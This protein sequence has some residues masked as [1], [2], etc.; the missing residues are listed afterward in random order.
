[1]ILAAATSNGTWANLAG[2]IAVLVALGGIIWRAGQWST[3]FESKLDDHLV[4]DTNAFDV[5][6]RRL[7]R[8]DQADRDELRRFRERQQP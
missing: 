3:R 8:F 7:D 5:I 1:M 2:V 6:A 4:S